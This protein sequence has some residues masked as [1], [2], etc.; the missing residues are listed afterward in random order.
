[1]HIGKAVKQIMIDIYLKVANKYSRRLPQIGDIYTHFK[2]NT[3]YIIAL[4]IDTETLH[5]SIVY[6]HEDNTWVRPLEMFL[7]EVDKVKYPNSVQQY[8][9]ERV[10]PSGA[11]ESNKFKELISNYKS[12]KDFDNYSDSELETYIL[13]HYFL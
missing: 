3:V 7:S 2:G 10:L 12:I 9:F 1:M 5:P 8:R 4:A 13:Q 6:R 11:K